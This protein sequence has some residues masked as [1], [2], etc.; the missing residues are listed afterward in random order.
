MGSESEA[1]TETGD[2]TA[3]AGLRQPTEDAYG[4]TRRVCH[5][6]IDQAMI[7]RDMVQRTLGLLAAEQITNLPHTRPMITPNA[8]EL[9]QSDTIIGVPTSCHSH[10]SA[11]DRGRRGTCD[12][13][14]VRTPVWRCLE[15]Q[16]L[17]LYLV[18]LVP[19]DSSRSEDSSSAVVYH[20][21]VDILPQV[22]FS[23]VD[24]IYTC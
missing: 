8:K 22:F 9:H 10:L 13:A 1:S 2:R 20:S 3:T 4:R 19:L 6:T 23:G 17:W 7:A 15:I 12:E 11:W 21:V 16:I 5:H 24:S 14:S 18:W